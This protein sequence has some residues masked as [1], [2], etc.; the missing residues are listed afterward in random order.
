MSNP[1]TIFNT[2]FETNPTFQCLKQ[3]QTKHLH[4]SCCLA[5][6]EIA[7][8]APTGLVEIAVAYYSFHAL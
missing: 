4:L 6:P 8:V 1:N 2:V 5:A 3:V 7:V